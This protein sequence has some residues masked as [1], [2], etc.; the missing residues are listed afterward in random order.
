MSGALK[1]LDDRLQRDKFEA[2]GQ[3]LSCRIEVGHPIIPPELG[4]EGH[5]M[6]VPSLFEDFRRADFEVE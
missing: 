3:V 1:N 4:S 5:S 6:R 2:R